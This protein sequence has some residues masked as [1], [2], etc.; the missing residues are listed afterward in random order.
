MLTCVSLFVTP[1]TIALQAPLSI[2]F[3][4]EECWSGLPFPP[5]GD[6]PDPG[7][8]PASPALQADSFTTEPPGKPMNIRVHVCIPESV[9]HLYIFTLLLKYSMYF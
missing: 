3:S 2:E 9:Y 4:S 1:W 5:P 7:I 8:K 6:L